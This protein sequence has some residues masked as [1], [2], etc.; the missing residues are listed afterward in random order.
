MAG[1]HGL[2]PLLPVRFTQA[3]RVALAEAVPDLA[4]RLKLREW[5]QR[6]VL[7]TRN[8]LQDINQ[9]AATAVRRAVLK[10]H[11]KT[12]RQVINRASQALEQ[13]QG[14]GAHP[15]MGKLFQ[16]K[17][18]LLS[19][20]PPVWRRIHTK[21]C[22]LDRL[23]EHIQLVMGWTNFHL[24]LDQHCLTRIHVYGQPQVLSLSTYLQRRP[25]LPDYRLATHPQEPE[26]RVSHRIPA[27]PAL[28]PPWHDSWDSRP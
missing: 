8:E 2:D 3:Q 17:I 10:T 21:D 13:V 15:C 1:P 6:T 4:A 7:F 16:F 25:V 12:L 14:T 5:N 28:E 24:P 9:K 18:T 11:R 23:H 19:I 26:S 22:T 20:Q 27:Y